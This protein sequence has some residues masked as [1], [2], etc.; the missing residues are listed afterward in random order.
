M[1]YS[2]F[3]DVDHRQTYKRTEYSTGCP[4]DIASSLKSILQHLGQDIC[5]EQHICKI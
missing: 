5:K 3:L 4:T 2:G 1:R